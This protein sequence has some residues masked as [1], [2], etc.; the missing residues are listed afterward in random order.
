MPARIFVQI[1]AFCDPQLYATVHSLFAN[2]QAPDDLH[3]AI[4]RQYNPADPCDELKEFQHDARVSIDNVLY[5]DSRGACWARSRCQQFYRQEPY[6]L[7]IDSH[8][9]FASQWDATL[10]IMYAELQTLCR[11]PLITAYVPAYSPSADPEKR[12]QEPW[13]MVF[14][15][16]TPEGAVIFLPEVIPHWQTLRGPVRARFLSGHFIFTAGRFAEEVP[17]MPDLYF[18]GE[19]ITMSVRAF[20]HGYDL[21]H[22]HQVVAWHE[23]T[24]EGRVKHWDVH[25]D[26]TVLN[27]A[28]LKKTRALL[29]GACTTALGTERTLEAYERYA[30]LLFKTKQVHKL[31]LAHAE[32]SPNAL[33]E[34]SLNAL[35]EPSPNALAE[36][37]LNALAEPSL[38][39]LAEPSPNALAEPCNKLSSSDFSAQQTHRIHLLRECFLEDDYDFWAIAFHLRADDTTLVRLDADVNEISKLL[40]QKQGTLVLERTFYHEILPMYWVVW[41]YS[42]TK[43]WCESLRGD[44]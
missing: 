29:T 28:A 14:D 40:Q 42:S 20:T 38:N 16:Y 11:K 30:G 22:P 39:A 10:I 12:G 9:R 5:A 21:F 7:Q 36:P 37:S 25:R 27:T 41:P 1:A 23:Y 31:T 3:V 35:A 19:E 17:Y 32:P 15:K 26:W 33:A 34:P 8:M 44:V 4:V 2:A 13:Q 24:R 18:I 6:T 43:G